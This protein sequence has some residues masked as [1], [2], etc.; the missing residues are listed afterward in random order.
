MKILHQDKKT[1]KIKIKPENLD[2]IWHLYNIIEKK[3]L[4][5]GIT[6]RT[7][8]NKDGIVRSKKS[9]KKKMK[10]GI[11]VEDVDFHEFSDRLRIKGIIEEGPQEHGSYHTLNVDAE[12]MNVISVIKDDWKS[13]QLERLKEAV[14]DTKK[15]ILTFISLDED[16][17]TIAVLRQSGLQHIADIQSHRSGK[18]YESENKE[19]EYFG[20]ILYLV[21]E[22]KK[23]NN[24]LVIV[25][26]GFTKDNLLK[27]G[28]ESKPELFER[29]VVHG[30]GNAGINGI[31]E[32]I[33]R[34]IVEQ[35]TKE[36]RV[37]YETK[38]LNKLF[39]EI[40][41]D[42]LATYGEEQVEYAL[43][44][45][46]VE[47]LLISDK[48]VRSEKGEKFIE[49]AKE[50]KSDFTII[51]TMHESGEKIEGLGGVAALLRFKLQPI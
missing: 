12:E 45:G 33:K 3:D 48:M 22:Y 49:K 25:G 34:G 2:D 47:R 39:E 15:G 40:K 46:A 7:E 42:G 19:R 20:E 27:Y 26:P 23:E 9:K 28:K 21:K 1:G 16:L 24:P 10:L 31:Y 36:N 41:K 38:L 5:R 6:F 13:H 51:N 44:N 37:S 18:M 17:A 4:V 32:A 29:C 30:T 14:R 11:R 8:E 43:G 50:N 35:I